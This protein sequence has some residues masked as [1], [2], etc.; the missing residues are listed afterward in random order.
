MVTLDTYT[1]PAATIDSGVAYALVGSI[2]TPIVTISNSNIPD[3]EIAKLVRG[4]LLAPEI[5]GLIF[6]AFSLIYGYAER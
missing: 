4:S 3:H 2:K 6:T 1:L 5:A